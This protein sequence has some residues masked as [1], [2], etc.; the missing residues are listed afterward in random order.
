[1]PCGCNL[2]RGIAIDSHVT[3]TVR[4]SRQAGE[5]NLRLLM[6][7][8]AARSA[9]EKLRLLTENDAARS[10]ARKIMYDCGGCHGI[11]AKK[12]RMPTEED[13]RT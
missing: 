11:A 9:A 4:T 6:Q 7:D 1:M 13:R 8:D 10:A 3:V 5:K 12:L 2:V